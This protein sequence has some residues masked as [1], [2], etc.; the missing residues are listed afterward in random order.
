M[1]GREKKQKP[2]AEHS[3]PT[4]SSQPA[5]IYG[6]LYMGGR[7]SL[8]QMGKIGGKKRE[9]LA[10]FCRGRRKAIES[11]PFPDQKEAVILEFP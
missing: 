3:T 8:A 11:G 6:G 2:N 9:Y 4:L 7:V 1:E 10:H 5:H